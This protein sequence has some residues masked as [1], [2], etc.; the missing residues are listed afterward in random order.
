VV[1]GYCLV[2][3]CGDLVV[4]WASWRVDGVKD[5]FVGYVKV[6]GK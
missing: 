1:V 5:D 2:V 6:M 3:I 4:G